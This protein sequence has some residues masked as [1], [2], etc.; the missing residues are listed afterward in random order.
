MIIVS[1]VHDSPSALQRLMALGEET[2]ILGDLVNLSDYRTGEGAVQR[3]MGQ[4]FADETRTARGEGNYR[5]MRELWSEA[6]EESDEDLR[7]RIGVELQSQYEAVGKALS[8][9]RGLVI[10]GNV[11]RPERLIACLPEGFEYVHGK[12]VERDGM[13]IGF[14]GGGVETPLQAAGELS[15]EEMSRILSGMEGVDVLCTHV[16]PAVRAL[17]N[18]VVTGREE[19]GSE[20]IREH[21]ERCQP[22]FHFFGD[23]HQ[24]QATTW[25]IGRTTCFNAGYFRATGRFLRLVDGM[26][27]SSNLG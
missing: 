15:D 11:D 9:G 6:S 2:A 23:V 21:L 27:Q 8:P 12:V 13:T 24:P 3:V 18:D 17:R 22:R 19:R 16:S 25:R 5:R 26:V 4:E 20:P 1:D 7:T 14:V 10:H